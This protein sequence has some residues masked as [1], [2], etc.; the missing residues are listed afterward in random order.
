M[1]AE[2][3]R[4]DPGARD[5]GPRAALGLISDRGFAPYFFGNALSATGW[6]F[7]TLAAQ[8]LVWRQTHS[9]LVLGV[10]SFAEFVPLLVL[11]PWAGA[12]ADRF[13]RKRIVL[14]TQLVSVALSGGLALLA[15]G[16]LAP[17]P[18]VVVDAFGLGLANVFASPAALALLPSL[19]GRSQVAAAVGLNSMTWN[20]ARAVGPALAAVTVEGLGIP[21]AFGIN[22]ASYL[23]LAVGVLVVRPRPHGRSPSAGAIRESVRLVRANPRLLVYLG[24]VAV[25][26]IAADPINTLA[27]AFA[28]AF[29]HPD[30]R[31]G[32]I[33][34]VFGA[35]A[36]GAAFLLTGRTARTSR[37]AA[38]RVAT[39]SAGIGVFAVL[40]SFEW[41]LP[42]LFVGGVGYLA[43]N[44]SA[45]AQLQ[46][47][48]GEHER[49]R[50]MALWNVAFLGLRP[51]ASLADGAI[52]SGFGVRAAGVV[53]VL[54][55][56]AAAL[57]LLAFG[58]R[59]ARLARV[60][61]EPGP[62]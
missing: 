26:G 34:G 37:R 5:A 11:S 44:T 23:A 27:P 22:A 18:V 52:A 30:T 39:M 45:T 17:T 60:A 41:A 33:I 13:D 58:D 57:L 24:I 20:L 55:A 40:P 38:L 16:G 32:L 25:V 4:D 9:G 43:T 2:P 47:S 49:G 3:E 62:G 15:W 50:V 42:V 61:Q 28:H 12:V 48:V 21:A 53:M 19:V 10:L 31:A 29:G 59:R 8:L 6:W 7:Q 46:L 36:V 14:V 56:V 35:G 54:P 1:Q 51:F